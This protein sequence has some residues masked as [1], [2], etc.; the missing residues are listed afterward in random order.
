MI[1]KMRIASPLPQDCG[2][3]HT[4]KMELTRN[5]WVKIMTLQVGGDFY[6]RVPRLL[7]HCISE[8]VYCKINLLHVV[9]KLVKFNKKS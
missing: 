2:F 1:S 7:Q 4:I 9:A 8:T 5:I 6:T 3:R